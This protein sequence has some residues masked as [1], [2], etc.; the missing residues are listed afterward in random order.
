M[1]GRPN[2]LLLMTDQQRGDALGCAGG[3]A[4]TPHIDRLAAQG[5][6]FSRC[7]TTSPECVPTRASLATGLY[8]HNTGVWSN[9]A[10]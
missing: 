10:L 5:V 1:S 2:L 7:V 9:G 6:R 4:R 8:P 3:W